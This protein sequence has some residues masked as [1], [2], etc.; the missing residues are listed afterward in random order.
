MKSLFEQ[1]GG[2]YHE[3]NGYFIPDL[4]LPDEEQRA[5]GIWGRRHL[6]YLKQ[7]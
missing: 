1:S 5:I 2:T 4:G 3:E 7:H 6:E